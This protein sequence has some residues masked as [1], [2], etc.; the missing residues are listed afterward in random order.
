MTGWKYWSVTVGG[1]VGQQDKHG[2][3]L[4]KGLRVTFLAYVKLTR[5]CIHNRLCPESERNLFGLQWNEIYLRS[6]N[7]MSLL[8]ES[9]PLRS[10]ALPHNL[11]LRWWHLP[12][13]NT[14]VSWLSYNIQFLVVVKQLAV[15]LW[16]K[17]SLQAETDLW[18]VWSQVYV[19]LSNNTLC[20]YLPHSF[21]LQTTR[22][23]ISLYTLIGT[24]HHA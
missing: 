4:K 18:S 22:L 3:P 7:T 6:K 14:L 8:H 23:Q 17:H 19:N 11:V 15:L 16:L 13:T 5:V 9:N 1:T 12:L 21:S 10:S 2:V 20:V 24:A